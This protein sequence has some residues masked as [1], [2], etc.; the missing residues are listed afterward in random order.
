MQFPYQRVLVL[1][2]GGAGKST[3][4]AAMGARFCLPVVHLDRLW[5]L[6]GW[7]NRS[8]EEFDALLCEEL[9]KPA[10]VMDGNYLRTLPV[11]LAKA[12][13]A[14]LLD[15]SA[16]EC[17]ASI[18][19]RVETYRGRS[20]PDM[21]EGCPERVDDEFETWIR[22]YRDET[23]PQVLRLLNGWDKP[24][25]AFSDRASA[26]AWLESFENRGGGRHFC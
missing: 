10:W 26:Y 24:W 2:C 11:R 22:T 19:A 6:P 4:S 18:W 23:L 5:W 21:P 8:E 7:V 3:Y 15:L 16:K 9:Q 25:F 20:R 14:V 1:G 13:C 17:L 12:D